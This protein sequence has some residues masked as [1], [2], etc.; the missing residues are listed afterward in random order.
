MN[1]AVFSIELRHGS[2]FAAS[3]VRWHEGRPSCLRVGGEGGA[4]RGM[5]AGSG[6]SGP[7]ALSAAGSP[8]WYALHAGCGLSAWRRRRIL[9]FVSAVACDFSVD[10]EAMS[11]AG[12]LSDAKGNLSGRQQFDLGSVTQQETTWLATT[13]FEVG[14]FRIWRWL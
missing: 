12:M 1:A 9:S 11:S 4:R 5:T 14:T 3:L 6:L 8:G 13:E 10:A 7:Q 2:I